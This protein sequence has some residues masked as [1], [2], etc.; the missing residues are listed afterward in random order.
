MYISTPTYKVVG[1]C[2]VL[3]TAII[4]MLRVHCS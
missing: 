4:N 2:I 1:E 3:Y